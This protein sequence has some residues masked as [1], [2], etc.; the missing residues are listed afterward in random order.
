MPE[1]L[2]GTVEISETRPEQFGVDPPRLDL[3]LQ[4]S[5][6]VPKGQLH[7]PDLRR[8]VAQSRLNREGIELAD[9]AV[10]RR[11]HVAEHAGSIDVRTHR[12]Y[13]RLVVQRHGVC[14]GIER[15]PAH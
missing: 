2:Q 15:T 9:H 8:C 4:R 12:E 3:S 14:I 13:R 5:P 11:R 10:D 6:E 7:L 1:R